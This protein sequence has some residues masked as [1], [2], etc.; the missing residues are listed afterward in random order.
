MLCEG[1]AGLLLV[2]DVRHGA[3]PHQVTV[4]VGDG[5]HRPHHGGPVVVVGVHPRAGHALT[6]VEGD[7]PGQRFV[8]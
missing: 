6:G 5:D 3:P 1:A 7:A 8:S 2:G 4:G